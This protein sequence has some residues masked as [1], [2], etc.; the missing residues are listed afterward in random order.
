MKRR[1]KKNLCRLKLTDHVELLDESR[2]YNRRE[3]MENINK[4]REKKVGA[5]IF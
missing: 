2:K 4:K 5:P 1:Q 3:P